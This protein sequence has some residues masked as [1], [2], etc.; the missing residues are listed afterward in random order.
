MLSLTSIKYLVFLLAIVILYYLL[1][2]KF[3]WISILAGNLCF[4][5]FCDSVKELLI[6]L[7]MA[8]FTYVAAL[9]SSKL[10]KDGPK[11]AVTAVAVIVLALTFILL[12]ASTFFGL[13]DYGISP[14]GISYFTLSWIA[15]LIEAYCGTGPVQ[16]NPFKFL[17]FAGFFPLLTSGPIVKYKEV[18]EEILAGNALSYQNLTEGAVRIVWGFLKKLVIADR[19]AILVNTVYA[20]PYRYP[21]FF[22][23]VANA[24]FVIQLYADFSGCIDIALG[25]ARMLGIRLPENFDLPFLSQT[26]EE[27]WRKW[28]VTLGGWLRDYILYPLLK[29]SLF[30]TIGKHSKKL[31]GK[32]IGKK[33]PTWIGMMISWF[34][35]GFWHG[36]G[37]NYIFGVGIL[38]GSIIIIGQILSPLFERILA[39]LHVKVNALSYQGF[40]IVRTWFFFATG[41]SFFR[42]GNL[43]DGF[44]NLKLTYTSWNPWIFFTGELYELGLD[45]TDFH[46]LLF[47]LA[48]LAIT[49]IVRFCTKKTI[50]AI[51]AEQNLLFRWIVYSLL[52][53]SIIIY[54]CY[55]TGF[56]SAS[57]IY[58]GF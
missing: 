20:N 43:M 46:I 25:S 15:Y 57:F 1:P 8:L 32:K 58:Q 37:W 22:F 55:G 30:Q 7:G 29:S 36:G 52:V 24:C 19:I 53:Y 54:G 50:C 6:W 51:M 27:F 31:F 3:R 56:S 14:I 26:M 13:P 33:I 23:H 17:T 5:Y 9:W 16:T 44:R 45:R 35:V 39:L 28:H 18:G 49:G 47:F 12:T 48:L 34:L 11:K 4:L 2:K 42:A 41:L 40:R 21:G 10:S 38:F